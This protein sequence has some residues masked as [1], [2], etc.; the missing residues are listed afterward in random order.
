MQLF[1]V[2]HQQALRF[3]QALREEIIERDALHHRQ[4][5]AI[6]LRALLLNGFE[7]PAHFRE[8]RHHA[9]EIVGADADELHVIERGAGGRANVAREQ[10]DFAEIIAARKIGENHVAP[11]MR[12]RNFHEADAHEIKA[13]GGIALAADDL[14]RRVTH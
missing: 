4:P 11:G 12:L 8:L 10:A 3:H 2:E 5:L 6:H 1:E 13:V 7:L 9:I 14:A